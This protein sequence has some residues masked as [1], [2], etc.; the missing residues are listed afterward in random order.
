MDD[1]LSGALDETKRPGLRALLHAADARSFDI[2]LVAAGDRLSRDQW[3]QAAILDRLSKAGVPL[4][5]YQDGR[6]AD[7]SGSVGKFLEAVRSFGS[8]FF[9][10]S[11]RAHMIDSLK[12]KAKAGHVHGGVT[13]GYDNVRSMAMWSVESTMP[14]PRPSV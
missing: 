7:L 11:A 4:W 10:E 12:R 13:F 6:E 8:E 3:I 5:Y 14:K 2:L 1:G 9:R